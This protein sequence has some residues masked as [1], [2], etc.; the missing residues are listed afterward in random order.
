MN[1]ARA[2]GSGVY[3]R[4]I[5]VLRTR[6]RSNNLNQL[7]PLGTAQ[8]LALPGESYKLAF[9]PGL[10]SGVYQRRH[11][12]LATEVLLPNPGA[13]LLADASAASDR[14]GYVDLEGDGRWWIPSGRVFF[15][16]SQTATSADE[17]VEALSHFFLPRRFLNSFS[18][19]SF[20]D[21]ASDLFPTRTR[22]ALGNRVEV[23]HDYRVLEARQLTDFN[24]NRSF[25]AF[26]ALGLPVAT[27]ARG[28]IS[29]TLGDSLDDFG[30]FDADP[31]LAEL[32][33]FVARPVNSKASLLKNATSR[34][35]Y[36]L[37]RFRR[38]GQ[39]PFAATL[40]RETHVSDASPAHGVPIQISFAY[41]DGFGRELQSKIQAEPG[42]AASRAAEVTLPSGDVATGALTLDDDAPVL[43]ATNPRWVGKGRTVYNNKGKPV[44]QY[45]PFFSSTHLFEVE[46]EMTDTGVTPILFYDPVE[47]VVATL[48]PNHSY[49]KVVFDPW[50]QETWDVNDS[51]LRS[52]PKADPD[53]G[54]FFQLLPPSDYLPTWQDQRSKGQRG[55]DEKVAA[56]KAAAHDGT[57][58][59][60]H[61]DALGRPMLTVADNGR[62]KSGA[63][64][65]FG[66]RVTLDIEGNQREVKDANARVVMRYDYDLLGNRIH[67]S[68]MEAGERWMLSDV[69]GKPIRAWDSR[70]H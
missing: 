66:T 20:V 52:D 64:Q 5:E 10:L 48:H 23:L 27:A 60:A 28:K 14:G 49:E 40:A 37:D 19:S 42:D 29:E 33:A 34:F 7:L 15:H 18:Q 4:P 56:E 25:V 8:A 51:V 46:P 58:T 9:T 21:Y 69:T 44:K 11:A 36:D 31:T 65:K 63:A 24:G 53:V 59:V 55:A 43:S 41:S 47:R 32:Q 1:A 2:L 50:R 68:S 61:L 67:Q 16:P 45:E 22:D 30:P 57:P 13:V 62:D 38:C 12:G 35:V 17:L 54:E 6:Y 3:R 70:G 39:P 26:D